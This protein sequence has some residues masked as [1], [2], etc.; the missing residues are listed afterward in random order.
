MANG[1]A[2][3]QVLRGLNDEQRHHGVTF[4]SAWDGVLG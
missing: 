2:L 1:P 4:V 3:E